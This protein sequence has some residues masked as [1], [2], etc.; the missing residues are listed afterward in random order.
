MQDKQKNETKNLHRGEKS[1]TS[2]GFTK[3][4]GQKRSFDGKRN[5]RKDRPAYST[6]KRSY[7][8]KGS[9]KREFSRGKGEQKSFEKKAYGKPDGESKGFGNRRFEKRDGEGGKRFERKPHDAKPYAKHDGEKR[10]GYIKRD[11]EK[12]EGFAPRDNRSGFSK[13]NKRRRFDRRESD[14]NR[15]LSRRDDRKPFVKRD[16]KPAFTKH[17]GEH[18]PFVRKD[19]SREE[20]KGVSLSR[21]SAFRILQDVTVRGAFTSIALDR[22]LAANDLLEMDKRLATSIVYTTLENMIKID[23]ILDAHM[24]KPSYEPVLRD[25]L[26]MSVAQILFMDKIPDFAAINEGV[27]LIRVVSIVEAW[28][29]VVNGV[30]RNILRN[31]ESFEWPKEE[32]GRERFLSVCY[33]MPLWLVNTL[34][35]R[36]GYE[37]AKAVITYAKADN[38][39][40]IRPNFMHTSIPAFEALLAKKGWEYEKGMVP[41]SYLVRNIDSIATDEDFQKGLFS[42]QGQSSMLA[43][44]AVENGLG[45]MVLDACAAPGGK[46]FY[47]AEKQQGSGRV[48]AWDLHAHRVELIRQQ[49]Y[50]L[51]PGNV[52]VAI[53]D[54]TQYRDDMFEL[55][56]RVLID[57]PCSNLGVMLEKPDVKYNAKEEEMP[58]L[59]DTQYKILENCAKY[60]KVGGILVYSTCSILP[61]ENYGQV[62]KFL[63]NNKNFKMLSMPKSFPAPMLAQENERGLEIFAHKSGLEGFYIAR[64]QKYE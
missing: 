3:R 55:F 34:I 18:K 63:Q 11:G 52:R 25:V 13:E 1:N 4:D 51:N 42:V 33:S 46:T 44:M 49:M 40:C 43:A 7:D 59:L 21:L 48:Y 38:R 47:M 57:A 61:E 15:E 58:A 5:D 28:S 22:V 17:D 31:K 39:T 20:N 30:L 56:D 14:A 60:L 54:A 37:E 19:A 36:F 50:R 12:R 8:R 2:N 35:D 32:D 6:E 26:R 64:M 23:H 10:E 24:E 27:K 45:M 9:E 62:E 29:G 53:C 41:N 16:D